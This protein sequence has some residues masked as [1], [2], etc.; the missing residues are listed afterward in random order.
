MNI[1]LVSVSERTKEIW[2]RKAIWAWKNDI[3]FQFLT[4]SSTL[5]LFWWIIWII[6]SYLVVYALNYF[7]ISA[8]ISINCIIISFVFSILI[9]IIFWLLPAYKRAKL[10]PI[11]TLRFE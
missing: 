10:R 5:S 8:I 2:I 1:M 7:Q 3:L 4:E 9:W 11:E 6:I